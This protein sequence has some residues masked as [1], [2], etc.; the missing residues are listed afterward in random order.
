MENRKTKPQKTQQL[1]K[2][3]IFLLLLVLTAGWSA[4]YAQGT[5]NDTLYIADSEISEE[6]E[7]QEQ[8]LNF[9]F[10][11][12]GDLVGIA[13]LKGD[14]IIPPIY[15]C[16]CYHENR[17][18]WQYYIAYDEQEHA[19]IFNKRGR[20]IIPAERGYVEIGETW[21]G[22]KTLAWNCFR[23]DERDSLYV[24]ALCDWQG[25]EVFVPETKFRC[26]VPIYGKHRLFYI[27]DSETEGSRVIDHD[28]KDC[29]VVNLPRGLELKLILTLDEDGDEFAIDL[30]PKTKNFFPQ[31]NFNKK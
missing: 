22:R 2:R 6:A 14:T 24:Y 25:E 27:A 8:E 10:L 12:D 21:G 26:I 20:C 31:K 30:I 5:E 19:A 9:Q 17:P 23:T 18:G 16:V 29:D 4:A 13:S 7:V 3:T 15:T 28:G 11:H 1:M